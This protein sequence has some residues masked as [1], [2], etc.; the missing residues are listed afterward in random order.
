LYIIIITLILKRII[1][2]TSIT[3][4]PILVPSIVRFRLKYLVILL[5]MLQ[6]CLIVVI[7]I[8]ILIANVTN[9]RI[10]HTPKIAHLAKTT[11]L[12][13]TPHN[14]ATT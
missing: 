5:T 14:V 4:A 13:T 9:Y 1:S 6:C 3:T 12:S 11:P 7:L 10:V 8:T 2:S